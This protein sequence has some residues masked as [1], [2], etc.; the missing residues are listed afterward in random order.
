VQDFRAE[1]P[2]TNC[3]N[4]ATAM[5]F[6][7]MPAAGILESYGITKPEHKDRERTLLNWRAK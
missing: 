5:K 1:R 6:I 7:E 4:L 2:A 3:L